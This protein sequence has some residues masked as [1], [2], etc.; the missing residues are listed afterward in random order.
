MTKK[1]AIVYGAFHNGTACVYV[2][3]TI[4]AVSARARQ[5]NSNHEGPFFGIA[6]RFDWR[7]MEECDEDVADDR[8]AFWISKMIHDGHALQNKL[9]VQAIRRDAA[10]FPVRLMLTWAEKHDIKRAAKAADL[11]VEAYVRFVFLEWKNKTNT[12]S[13]FTAK[14]TKAQQKLRSL[15]D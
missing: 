9:D 11:T 1:P 7:V 5:H 12:T 14:P 4:L 2:G 3:Q 15:F 8:E 6:D 13:T 10:S